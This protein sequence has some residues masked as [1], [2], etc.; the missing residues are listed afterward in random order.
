[1]E[2]M[3]LRDVVMPIHDNSGIAFVSFENYKVIVLEKKFERK[4]LDFQD[5]PPWGLNQS[6]GNHTILSHQ[7]TSFQRKKIN[8]ILDFSVEVN[9]RDDTRRGRKIKTSFEEVEREWLY[10]SKR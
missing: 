3:Y 5:V 6:Q 7:F 1:M 2:D 9:I 8:D 10:D 4:K